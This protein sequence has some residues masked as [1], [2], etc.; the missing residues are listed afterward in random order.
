MVRHTKKASTAVAMKEPYMTTEEAR[1]MY[2]CHCAGIL[3]AKTAGSI[4][5][6]REA[7]MNARTHSEIERRA[8]T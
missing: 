7:I 5:M 6:M 3:S 1:R 4:S 2:S 8:S